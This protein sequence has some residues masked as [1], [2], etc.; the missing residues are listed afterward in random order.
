[1]H[2]ALKLVNKLNMFI[3]KITHWNYKGNESKTIISCWLNIDSWSFSRLETE[4]MLIMPWFHRK[5]L[6]IN[7]RNLTGGGVKIPP[8]YLC[9][10]TRYQRNFNSYTYDLKINIAFDIAILKVTLNVNWKPLI[11]S[12]VGRLEKLNYLTPRP[13]VEPGSSALKDFGV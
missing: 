2:Y 9:F 3:N 7:P 5:T 12:A 11:L 4:H 1:M 8:G 10:Q 13:G 6:C